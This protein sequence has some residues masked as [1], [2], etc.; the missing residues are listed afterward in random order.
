MTTV[1]PETTALVDSV[2]DCT[3]RS[4]DARN[5]VDIIGLSIAYCK[6]IY[7]SSMEKVPKTNELD[8]TAIQLVPTP[9]LGFGPSDGPSGRG[10]HPQPSEDVLT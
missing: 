8:S 5:Y 1:K 3:V 7:V 10:T 2:D 9:T 4:W 6:I